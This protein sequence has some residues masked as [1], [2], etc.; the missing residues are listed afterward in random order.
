MRPPH[1]G[2]YTTD[3]GHPAAPPLVHIPSIHP[4]FITQRAGRNGLRR[5]DGPLGPRLGRGPLPDGQQ[6]GAF[7]LRRP[8]LFVGLILVLRRTGQS[9]MTGAR[10][11][12][13]AG[14]TDSG[15]CSLFSAPLPPLK[16]TGENRHSTYFRNSNCDGTTSESSIHSLWALED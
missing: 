1:H 6:R 2:T 16:Y 7:T 8:L 4:P 9:Q 10:T 11:P 3:R 13:C 5:S 12:G 15:G 14:S